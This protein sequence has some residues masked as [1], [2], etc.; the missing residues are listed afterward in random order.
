MNLFRK[1]VA[2]IAL[3]TLVISTS[4]TSFAY[5]TTDVTAANALAAAKVINDHSADPAKY[6]LE[7]NVLRQETAKIAVNLNKDVT[8]KTSCDN[9]FSDITAT[10]PNDWICGYAEALRDAG[11]VSANAKFNPETNVSK[12]EAVKM[13]LDAAGCTD[14]YSDAAKWQSQTV[15]FAAANNIASSFTDYNTPASRAFV[16]NVANN[17]KNTCPVQEEACDETLAALGLC[18]IDNGDTDNGNTDN[19]DTDNGDTDNG[20][21]DNGNTEATAS[22]K[23]S[24]QTPVD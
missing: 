7:Q 13:M 15:E 2:S 6:N 21:T 23:I 22:V 10:T 19:G 4:A 5:E 12:S 11:K 9:E 8:V 18:E 16:F 14:F 17:A 20:N 1:V 3:A 24:A